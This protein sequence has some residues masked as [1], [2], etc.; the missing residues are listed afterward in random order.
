[1]ARPRLEAAVL[2]QFY[3]QLWDALSCAAA[4]ELLAL[5]RWG[6][7]PDGRS[8]RVLARLC[9]VRE[10]GNEVELTELGRA[11]CKHGRRQARGD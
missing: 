1:M 4:G 9:L 8:T 2:R 7:A 10:D 3:A 5:E 11:V 6:Y